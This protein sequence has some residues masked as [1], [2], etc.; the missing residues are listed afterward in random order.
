M[1]SREFAA[2][3]SPA[4]VQLLW[5]PSLPPL[6]SGQQPD[7]VSAA[8]NVSLPACDSH[9]LLVSPVPPH[10]HSLGLLVLLWSLQ[11]FLH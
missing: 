10:D 5:Q 3:I 6:L 4:G 2:D 9:L 7:V 8:Q 11:W 1:S